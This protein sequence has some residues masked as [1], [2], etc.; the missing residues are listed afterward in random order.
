MVETEL[1]GNDSKEKDNINICNNSRIMLCSTKE[2]LREQKRNHLCLALV[3]REVLEIEKMSHVPPEIQP[4]LNEFKEIVGD[5]L[6]TGLPPLR[7]ISHQIDL[8]L[9][10]SL[11]NKAPYRMTPTESEEVNK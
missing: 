9:G 5:D 10:S 7:S 4:L 11:P 1:S 6:P 3:P 8:I 2:F